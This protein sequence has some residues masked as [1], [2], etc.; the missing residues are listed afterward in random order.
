MIFL[1]LEKSKGGIENVLVVTD[2]FT[3]YAQAYPTTNQTAR[4]NAKALFELFCVHYGFPSRIHSDQRRNFE[5]KL[6]EELCH[7]TGTQ[8]S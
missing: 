7:L 4:T 8:K 2:H 5:S 3:K 6:I 1:K